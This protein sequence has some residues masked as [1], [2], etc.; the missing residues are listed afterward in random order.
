MQK[1]KVNL[2]M[3]IWKVKSVKISKYNHWIQLPFQNLASVNY[4][5]LQQMLLEELWKV[6]TLLGVFFKAPV[7]ENVLNKDQPGWYI[8]KTIIKQNQNWT[9]LVSSLIGDQNKP[10]EMLN[11]DSITQTIERYKWR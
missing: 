11:I 2:Q 6:F 7:T 9:I 5:T 10:I 3:L 8:R 1:T 4:Q